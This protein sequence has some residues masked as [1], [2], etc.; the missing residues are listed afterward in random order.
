MAPPLIPQEIYLLERFCSLERYADMRD[1]WQAML[2]H[3]EDML[4][5]FMQQLPPRYRKRAL[6]EQPDIV[7]GERVL[8]NFRDTMQILNDGYIQLAHGDYEALGRANGVTGDVRGQTMDYSAA[9]MDEVEP[10]AEAKYYELLY[11]A[12]NLAW[13][14][15]L[16]SGGTWGPGAL[17][18]DYDLSLIHI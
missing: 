7:W 10:G 13:P 5:R 9:W 16:T 17:T 18:T 8:P 6:P 12:S 11:K 3:A 15:T 2:N 14:I 1:A 4:R